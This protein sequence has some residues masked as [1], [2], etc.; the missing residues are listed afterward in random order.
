MKK[1]IIIVGLLAFVFFANAQNN[2]S[3][4]EEHIDFSVEN[5][6]FTVNGI[7][8]FSSK[9]NKDEVQQIIFP[10][11]HET[12]SIDSIRVFNLNTFMDVEFKKLRNSVYFIIN[13]PANDTVDL[14]I[15]YR[16]KLSLANKY[17]ITSTQSWG[18]PLKIAEY[19]LTTDSALQIKSFTYEP[20]S[21]SIIDSKK[22]YKWVKQNFMP[23][24]DFEI[25]LN[26]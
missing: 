17:I 25:L 7:Y 12:K 15:F 5:N 3:F 19:T 23:K 1:I 24:K 22:V 21:E 4:F 14:N 9:T 20:E 13:I 26:D 8:S 18:E 6:F 2:V 11:D 16:Q 10:F